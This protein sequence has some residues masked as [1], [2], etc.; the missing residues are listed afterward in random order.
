MSAKHDC[1][2]KAKYAAM[3]YQS[4]KRRG[5]PAPREIEEMQAVEKA[6][7]WIGQGPD[8]ASHRKAMYGLYVQGKSFT[9]AANDA[10]Y[11]KA[12]AKP[13][14]RRFIYKVAEYMGYG[15]FDVDV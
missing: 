11:T 7:D 10:G 12:G 5:N 15:H 3:T 1:Y 8:G 6:L 13:I 14:H 4:M 9:M 2:W